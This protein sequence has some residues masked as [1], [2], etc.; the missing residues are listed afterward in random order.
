MNF[1]FDTVLSL[2]CQ[3]DKLSK[4]LS[5]AK[6]SNQLLVSMTLVMTNMMIILGQFKL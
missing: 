5:G 4:V 3:K 2:N 1:C 6:T